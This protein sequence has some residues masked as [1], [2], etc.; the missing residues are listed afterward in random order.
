M[1]GVA[2]RRGWRDVLLGGAA[3]SAALVAWEI[4]ARRDWL[5][6]LVCP[7]P[8]AIAASLAALTRT[9][10]LPAHTL[11]TLTRTFLGLAL[12][13]L[14]GALVGLLMGRSRRWR[15]LLD[16][17]VAALHPVPKIA[18]LPLFLIAFGIGESSKVVVVAVSAFFPM[19]ISAMA[20]VREISP[21]HFEVARSYG[22]SRLKVLTRVV[23]PGSLPLLLAGTRL[24][25]NTALLLTVAVELILTQNGLG[26]LIWRAWQTLRVEECY[27]SLA[28]IAVLGFVFNLALDRLAAHLAPWRV[29][30]SV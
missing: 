16:P 9:G 29:E 28:V 27:A 20:G 1:T 11:A 18:L 21:R 2:S 8:S 10:E 17:L 4:L 26:S 5:P 6:T 24:A 7:P 15:R 25:L 12:G 19:L 3:V 14:P 22:A 23:L 13:A 30:R